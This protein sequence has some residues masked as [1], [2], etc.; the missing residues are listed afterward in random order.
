MAAADFFTPISAS[1]SRAD[2]FLKPVLKRQS[3]SFSSCR[4]GTGPKHCKALL[5]LS[6]P[7]LKRTYALKLELMDGLS[8]PMHLC[9]S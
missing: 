5:E 6:R 1:F 9:S 3:R 4:A 7:K 2:A 8:Q